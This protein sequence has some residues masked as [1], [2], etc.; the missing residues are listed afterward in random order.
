MNNLVKNVVGPLR[1]SQCDVEDS[2]LTRNS[3]ESHKLLDL[4]PLCQIAA[5]SCQLKS[6]WRK[7]DRER[8][9]KNLILYT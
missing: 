5:E 9:I 7:W 3:T 1:Q 6:N 4:T 2:Q 8:E